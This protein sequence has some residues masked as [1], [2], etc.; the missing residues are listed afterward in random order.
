MRLDGR[1]PGTRRRQAR[2]TPRGGRCRR[3]REGSRAGWFVAGLQQERTEAQARQMSY[4]ATASCSLAWR[5]SGAAQ[6]SSSRPRKPMANTL[7]RSGISVSISRSLDPSRDRQADQ[8]SFSP[9]ELAAYLDDW[10]YVR[11]AVPGR[12]GRR[13]CPQV[14]RGGPGR[15]SR[16]LAQTRSASRSEGPTGPRLPR[17]ADDHKALEGQPASSLL[18]LG[19]WLVDLRRGFARPEKI[20]LRAWRLQPDDFWINNQLGKLYLLVHPL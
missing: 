15:R 8:G 4:V 1:R 9:A 6:P 10:A 14:D 19:R 13:L 7:L 11:F 2:G 18:L 3:G 20:L 17:L 16:P 5:R 12:Q